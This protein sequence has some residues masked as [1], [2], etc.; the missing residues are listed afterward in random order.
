[1][2]GP[3][4]SGSHANVDSV[5]TDLARAGSMDP[6]NLTLNVTYTACADCLSIS[7]YPGATVSVEAIYAYNPI[8]VLPLS[9]NLRSVS[10]GVITF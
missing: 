9:V 4:D 8:S 2:T 1:M 3:S 7:N 6:A 5:V 10:Q